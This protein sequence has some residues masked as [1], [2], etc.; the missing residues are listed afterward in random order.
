MNT[1][2][3]CLLTG[4]VLGAAAVTITVLVK[5]KKLKLGK[6]ILTKKE[7]LA[8]M[9]DKTHKKTQEVRDIIE[10][11]KK[12]LYELEEAIDSVQAGN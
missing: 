8:I 12:T 1:K 6:K 5:T 9:P 2:E 11:A 10:Q 7:Q 3:I 4:A